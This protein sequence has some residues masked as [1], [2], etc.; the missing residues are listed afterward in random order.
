MREINLNGH[1]FKMPA[2]TI[3]T[4]RFGNLVSIEESFAQL[5]YYYKK[6]GNWIDT[7]RV[8]GVELIPKQD[9]KPEYV[10]SEEAI[11]AWVRKRNLR[12]KITIVT[13][14]AHWCLETKQKRVSAQAIRDDF[15]LSLQKLDT[16][17]VDIY[18]LHNDDEIVPVSEIMPVMHELIK[19]GKARAIGASN[20]RVQRIIEA[21]DYAAENDLTPFSISQVKWS[22]AITT[23]NQPKPTIDMHRDKTQYEGYK[24]IGMPIMA[25]SSQAG[26]FFLKAAQDGFSADTLEGGAARFLC[27]ENIRRAEI[28]KELMT[29]KNISASAASLGYLWSRGLPVTALVGCS[30]LKHLKVSLDI[31][32]NTTYDPSCYS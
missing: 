30:T 20:W 10:D 32:D 6:G 14:G 1:N 8:Y 18:L 23:E 13:K 2:I 31:C 17:Y 15:A 24:A 4:V 19:S 5:D 27:D 28:V 22:Y 29:Q 21:N 16:N 11:G 7:A 9:R 25:Y 3:G 12:D 26:G